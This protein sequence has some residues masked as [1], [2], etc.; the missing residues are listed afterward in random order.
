[1]TTNGVH[2]FQF[3]AFPHLTNQGTCLDIFKQRECGV[4]PLTLELGHPL[5]PLLQTEVKQTTQ[6]HHV[7]VNCTARTFLWCQLESVMATCTNT[8]ASGNHGL[9]DLVIQWSNVMCAL[10]HH[11]W[12]TTNSYKAMSKVL[13]TLTFMRKFTRTTV[14]KIQHSS[15]RKTL[16][17]RKNPTL[18][19]TPLLPQEPLPRVNDS[20]GVSGVDCA[21]GL[22]LCHVPFAALWSKISI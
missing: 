5:C 21:N 20:S 14:F 22:W 7:D 4:W 18:L 10:M 6:A 3:G 8:V 19:S 15:S 11:H 9:T 13:F 2:H 17:S 12:L 16:Q 1:M